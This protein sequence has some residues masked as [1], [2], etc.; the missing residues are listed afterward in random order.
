MKRIYSL[1]LALMAVQMMFAQTPEISLTLKNY[2][3]K[4]GGKG[5]GSSWA[6]AMSGESLFYVLSQKVTGATF[7]LAEGSYDWSSW[8]EKTTFPLYGSVTIIGGYDSVNYNYEPSKN[9]TKILNAPFNIYGENTDADFKGI[10]FD[11]SYIR[12]QAENVNLT[13]ENCYFTQAGQS[14]NFDRVVSNI[15]HASSVSTGDIKLVNDTF[16]VYHYSESYVYNY[17]IV[18]SRGDSLVIDNCCLRGNAR[19]VECSGKTNII[20]N[21]SLI[22][23]GDV[24]DCGAGELYLINN[25]ICYDG[26]EKRWY[27]AHG[28]SAG[29]T[30]QGLIAARVPST[31]IDVNKGCSKFVCGENEMS[32]GR[33]YSV[34]ID[35]DVPIYFYKN[36]FGITKDGNTRLDH[37]VGEAISLNSNASCVFPSDKDSSNYVNGSNHGLYLTDCS[38]LDIQSFIFNENVCAVEASGDLSSIQIHDNQFLANTTCIELST[39]ADGLTIKNNYF[40]GNIN[41]IVESSQRLGEKPVLIEKNIFNGVSNSAITLTKKDSALYKTPIISEVRLENKV[42]EIEGSIDTAIVADIELFYND[43]RDQSAIQSIGKYKTDKKGHFLITCPMSDIDGRSRYCFTATAI[44]KMGTSELSEKSCICGNDTTIDFVSIQPN[45]EFLGKV[46]TE[47]GKYDSVPLLLKNSI[48]CDS[49]VYYTVLVNAPFNASYYVKP[50][51]TGTGDGSSWKDAMSAE[52]FAK[53]LP[54]SVHNNTFYVAEGTYKPIYDENLKKPSDPRNLCYLI[55]GDVEII[56]GYPIDAKMS[57]KNNPD[58]YKT[59]FDGE[60]E[61]LIM[62]KLYGSLSLS[63]IKLKG[64]GYNNFGAI[65]TYGDNLGLTIENSEFYENNCVVKANKTSNVTIDGCSFDR[66]ICS[67]FG[68]VVCYGS[69]TVTNSIFS[70]NVTLN[71]GSAITFKGSKL[72]IEK[73]T[74]SENNITSEGYGG[75]VLVDGGVADI[76][77][78]TFFNNSVD[79]KSALH[80][81]SAISIIGGSECSL[82]NNTVI[83]NLSNTIPSVFVSGSSK[84]DMIGNIVLNNN[85]NVNSGSTITSS[86]N[87]LRNA[88]SSSATDVIVTDYKINTFMETEL[89]DNTG[90]TP[91]VAL[92]SDTLPDGTSLRFP[93]KQGKVSEDQRDVRRMTDMCMGSFELYCPNDT[94]LKYDSIYVGES[95]N[96]VKYN[97]V[98]VYDG[99]YTP[100]RTETGCYAILNHILF[101][102]PD[103]TVKK[104]YVKME[105]KNKGDGSNWRNA[106]NGD[107]F[108]MYVSLVPDG[109]TFYVAEGTYRPYRGVSYLSNQYEINSNVTIIGG[110]PSGSQDDEISEPDKYITRFDGDFGKNDVAELIENEYGKKWDF[111]NSGDNAYNLFC[112]TINKKLNVN[113]EGITLSN[114]GYG[115]YANTSK[116]NCHFNKVKFERIFNYCIEHLS[117]EGDVVVDNSKFSN[118]NGNCIYVANNANITVSNTSFVNNYGGSYLIYSSYGTDLILLDKVSVSE[119]STGGV[120]SYGDLIIRNSSFDSNDFSNYSFIAQYSGPGYKLQISNSSFTNNKNSNSYFVYSYATDNTIIESCLFDH[121]E[122]SPYLCQSNSLI[123]KDSKVSNNITGNELFYVYNTINLVRDTISSNKSTCLLKNNAGIS[124]DSC[125][126]NDNESYL[127]Y[128]QSDDSYNIS[129]SV[130]ENN[131]GKNIY[132]NNAGLFDIKYA[133]KQAELIIRNN[134]FIGNEAVGYFLYG[135]LPYTIS[136]CLF[137]KNKSGSYLIGMPS[138]GPTTTTGIYNSTFN[139][140]VSAKLMIFHCCGGTFDFNNNTVVSNIVELKDGASGIFELYAP[141]S[142]YYNYKVNNNTI[143]GNTAKNIIYHTDEKSYFEGNIIFGNVCD[144]YNSGCSVDANYVKNN[145]MPLVTYRKNDTYYLSNVKSNIL[146][147]FN[148]DKLTSDPEYVS[149]V[150]DAENYLEEITSL[151]AGTYDKSTGLFTPVLADNGGVTP[152]VALKSDKLSDGTSIRFPRLYNVLTDQRGAYRQD[153]TCMGAYEFGCSKDTVNAADTVVVGTKYK[154]GKVYNVIGRHDSVFITY[155]TKF[156]CDSVVNYTLFVVPN[157]DIKEFYVKTQKA[158]KGDG[159]D[160]DNA[161]GPKD[162]AY[163]FENLQTDGVTF[164]VAAGTYRAV[165]DGWGKETNNKNAH[166][167][168]RHSANIYGGYDSLATGDASTTKPNFDLYKT[169]FTGDV[170]NDD[171][172]KM[173][174]G[175]EYTFENFSDNMNSSMISMDVYGDVHISGVELTGMTFSHGT[176]PALIRL[177]AKSGTEYSATIDHCKLSVADKGIE[178]NNISNLSVDQCEFDYISNPAVYSNGDCKVSNSTFAYTAGISYSGNNSGLLVENSTFVM[179]RSDI[180][181]YNYDGKLSVS[182]QIYNNTFISCKNGAYLSFYDN[183]SAS[184]SGNIFAGSSISIY[185]RDGVAKQQTFTNNLLACETFEIGESGIDKDNV[186]VTDITTLYKDIFEGS[187]SEADAIFT[188][189]LTYKGAF[190]R[191]VALQK[192][193]LEDGTSIR[194]PRLKNVL[195]D[196]RGT[197]RFEETCMGAYEIGCPEDTTFAVDTVPVGTKIYGQTF[198][199]VGVHDSIFENL[200]SKNGCDSIVMHKVVVRPTAL[201]YY[202]KTKRVNKGDGRDWD[203]AMSGEDFATYLP[204]APDGATFYVAAG[205]YKPIYDAN[206]IIPADTA[207]I[208]Y[209]I[210]SS[211]TIIGGYP[212]TITKVGT[213]S[214]PTVNKTIFSGDI[215]GDDEEKDIEETEECEHFSI[216]KG[217]DPKKLFSVNIDGNCDITFKNLMITDANDGINLNSKNETKKINLYLDSIR[218]VHMSNTAIYSSGK[219]LL[220]VKNTD[221][222][223]NNQCVIVPMNVD[224]KKVNFEENYGIL[225]YDEGGEYARFDSCFFKG[226]MGALNSQCPLTITNSEFTESCGNVI[227]LSKTKED[228]IIDNC[229]FYDNSSDNIIVTQQANLLIDKSRFEKNI[230]KSIGVVTNNLT[231]SNSVFAEN[232]QK[233]GASLIVLYGEANLSNDTFNSNVVGSVIIGLSLDNSLFRCIFSNNKVDYVL[234]YSSGITKGI[235]EECWFDGNE[236]K[237]LVLA[238]QNGKQIFSK[239]TFSNN[240]ATILLYVTNIYSNVNEDVFVLF[241]NNSIVNN[242]VSKTLINQTFS[243]VKYVNNTIVGNNIGSEFIDYVYGYTQDVSLPF[244]GNLIFGNRFKYFCQHAL[245]YVPKYNLMPSFSYYAENTTLVMPDE[246]NIL[247]EYSENIERYKDYIDYKY[248]GESYF[249]NVKDRSVEISSLFEGTYDATTGIFTPVLKNNGG[250]TPTVALK[251]DVLPDGTS[252]RFPRLENVLADQRGVERLD[253]TCMGAYEMKCTPIITELKDTVV[254]GDSYTFNEKNLDDVCQKVGSYYFSDTLTG[255][256]GCDSIVNLSLAVRPQKNENG[257]YVKED[258]TG[259]GSD[260][261]NAMSPKDFAEFLPL[262]YDGETFH[263]AAGTYKS[264]YVDPELGRMYNINSSVTLIGGYPDT[265]MS[266]ATPSMPDLFVTKLTADVKNN[267]LIYYYPNSL[268]INSYYKFDDNDSILIRLNGEKTLNLFGLTLSGVNSCD[269][270]VVDLSEGSS[271]VMDHCTVEDNLA[272]AVYGKGTDVQVANSVFT[273]NYSNNG[274]AFHLVDSKL[275]VLSS[276]FH[277]NMANAT[278][279]C[280]VEYS[281][282]GVASLINTEATFENSTLVNNSADNGAVFS[283]LSSKLDLTNNTISGNQ[284]IPESKYKGSVISSLDDKSSVSLFG[285]LVIGNQQDEFDGKFSVNSTDYNVYSFKTDMSYGEHDMIMNN[286]KEVQMLLD[287]EMVYGS[288]TIYI[289]KVQ[290]NGG[291][292]PT[293]AVVQSPFDGGKILNIPLDDRKVTYDQR[294]FVRKDSSCIGAFEFPTYTGYYVKKQAHGDGSGRDWENSMSDTTF[295]KYFSIVPANASFYIAE[296]VYTP[297][298]DSYGKLTDD[299][300][301]RYSTSRLLNI[302]GGYP[303]SAQTGCEADPTKYK[304]IFSVDYNGDD[305]YLESTDEYSYIDALNTLDNGY[306]IVDISSKVPGSAEIKGV[307][308]RGQRSVP[309]ASS[310][311]LQVSGRS[312][313]GVNYRIEQCSFRSCYAGI[314]SSCDTFIISECLFDSMS[315]WGVSHSSFSLSENTYLLVEKSTFANSLDFVHAYSFNGLMRVQNCTFANSLYGLTTPGGYKNTPE[316]TRVEIYNNSFFPGKKGIC[317]MSI[318]DYVPVELI[319]NIYASDKLM[320]IPDGNKK[321]PSIPVV[322][323]YNVYTAE[324]DALKFGEN[325][326][327]VEESSLEGVI[328]GA[329]NTAANHFVGRLS[330]NGGFADNVAVL[331]TLVD[332]DIDIRFPLVNTNVTED[333]NNVERMEFTC[334]G[335]YEVQCKNPFV[336]EGQVM[337]E[338]SCPGSDGG[339]RAIVKI[340]DQDG[341]PMEGKFSFVNKAFNK[342]IDKDN[343]ELYEKGVYVLHNAGKP[344][345][346]IIVKSPD[347]VVVVPLS[348]YEP[349]DDEKSANIKDAIANNQTCYGINNGSI[350]IEYSDFHSYYD[351]SFAVLSLADNSILNKDV[352]DSKG[353]VKFDSVPAGTYK[354]YS[355]LSVEGCIIEGVDTLYIDT[356]E[357]TAPDKAMEILSISPAENHCAVEYDGSAEV[358]VAGWIPETGQSWKYFIADGDTISGTE[359]E[360]IS[361]DTFKIV[362]PNLKG[363]DYNFILSDAC[364]QTL[365]KPFEIVDNIAK[366]VTFDKTIVGYTCPSVSNGKITYNV[367]NWNDAYVAVFNGDTILP[368]TSKNGVATFVADNLSDSLC[369]LNVVNMCNEEISDSTDLYTYSLE[370]EGFTI[371]NVI[372]DA[373]KAKCDINARILDVTV[374]GGHKNEY[375]FCVTTLEG[376]TVEYVTLDSAHFLSKT[377]PDG[378]FK[379]I[380]SIPE[381]CTFEYDKDLTVAPTVKL[382]AR[383][384]EVM[385]GDKKS[386]LILTNADSESYTSDLYLMN[387]KGQWVLTDPISNGV[388]KKTITGNVTSNYTAVK[389]IA[390]G[391]EIFAPIEEYTESEDMLSEDNLT[392]KVLTVNQRCFN[393]KNGEFNL[394][395]SNFNSEYDLELVA[396][397]VYTNTDYISKEMNPDTIHLTD[398]D[399]GLYDVSIRLAIGGCA[400]DGAERSLGQY[401]IEGVESMLKIVKDTVSQS[402]CYSNFVASATIFFKDW[403]KDIYSWNYYLDDEFKFNGKPENIGIDTSIT[404]FADRGGLAK[405]AIFDVCKDTLKR[406]FVIDSLEKP[407]VEFL[408]DSSY[409]D[410]RCAYDSG[411]VVVK[412]KGGNRSASRFF[413]EYQTPSKVNFFDS[414]PSDSIFKIYDFIEGKP[415]TTSPYTSDLKEKVV[416]RLDSGTY[417][418]VYQNLDFENCKGDYDLDRI[419]VKRPAAV[420]LQLAKNDVR[421]YDK[422]EGIVNFVPIRAGRAWTKYTLA[423]DSDKTTGS[424]WAKWL[425]L[426]DKAQYEKY[427][428]GRSLKDEAHYYSGHVSESLPYRSNV[429]FEIAKIAITAK[430]QDSTALME[431]LKADNVKTPLAAMRYKG[432]YESVPT[433]WIGFNTLVADTYYVAVTDTF[434]CIY[435][436]SFS[437]KGPEDK[438]LEIIDVV[439]PAKDAY[440]VAD[441][442]RIKFSATGGWGEYIFSVRNLDDPN[443]PNSGKNIEELSE[444]EFYGGVLD[445]DYVQDVKYDTSYISVPEKDKWQKVVTYRSPIL[446]PGRHVI[447]V[448]DKEFCFATADTIL[449]DAKYTLDGK[450]FVDWCGDPDN[451]RLVPIVRGNAKVDSFSVR[452]GH[453]TIKKDSVEMRHRQLLQDIVDDNNNIVKGLGNLPMGKIGVIAYMEDGCSAFNEFTYERREGFVPL[454]IV[455]KEFK[456]NNC[457]DDNTGEVFIDLGGGNDMYTKFELDGVDVDSKYFNALY[458][459]RRFVFEDLDNDGVTDTSYT[460]SSEPIGF[461]ELVNNKDLFKKLNSKY[462]PRSVIEKWA[463]S[464]LGENP[465]YTDSLNA[466]NKLWNSVKNDSNYVI[467]FQ[468]LPW[469]NFL[470]EDSL[471]YMVVEDVKGCVD[472]LKFAIPHPDKLEIEVASSPVCPD[473]AGRLFAKT[474]KGG[475]PPYSWAIDNFSESEYDRLFP[476]DNPNK[477]VPKKPTVDGFVDFEGYSDFKDY[478]TGYQPSDH[479]PAMEGETHYMYIK[480]SHDCVVKSG[481]AKVDKKLTWDEISQ[482]FIVSTWHSYGDVLVIIDKTDYEGLKFAEDQSKYPYTYD[483]MHVEVVLKSPEDEYMIATPQ[484]KELYTYGIPEINNVNSDENQEELTVEW[485]GTKYVGPIWG[486]PAEVA[487]TVRTDEEYKQVS[488]QYN[489]ERGSLVGQIEGLKYQ[490]L[491]NDSIYNHRGRYVNVSTAKANEALARMIECEKE[492]KVLSDSLDRKY[493]DGSDYTNTICNISQIK[494]AFKPLVDEKEA[495]RMSFI[496]LEPTS[497]AGNNHVKEMLKNGDELPFLL[498]TTAYVDGC[499]ITTEHNL[500]LTFQD[501]IPYP[502]PN[503]KETLTLLPTPNPATNGKCIVKATLNKRLD[504]NNELYYYLV[505]ADGKLVLDNTKLEGVTPV[506]IKIESEGSNGE[507]EYEYNIPVEGLEPGKEYIFVA[508]TKNRIESAKILTK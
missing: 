163:I 25:K 230:I 52:T 97:K 426:D 54:L 164:Y 418:V 440:C 189:N 47:V 445:V 465:T 81:G 462:T 413:M 145:I 117:E 467:R 288:E 482:D 4:E 156:D 50:E 147:E 232:K 39:P 508:T 361:D 424:N 327:L 474:S 126:V 306:Y 302:Y 11:E 91:T 65:T 362:I 119:C 41:G 257:Y 432:D 460:E 379:V 260:W 31:I 368:E 14:L 405:F 383:K 335:A 489:T 415:D 95:F 429:F 181:T 205:T 336:A 292:T 442:R 188:P 151:F 26:I 352:R 391:C 476:K 385:C 458:F 144:V 240:N 45:D 6:K 452:I 359:A 374:K 148:Y 40:E 439:P 270:G 7:H 386:T 350:E 341:N 42:F 398:L 444:N 290:N 387:E 202:V 19:C 143:I 490:W 468:D 313:S 309:R 303:D 485:K 22:S 73:C 324:I 414:V 478:Y 356:L 317:G 141:G 102:K 430:N 448:F 466:Y 357:I 269:R 403:Q 401:H 274:A 67:Q 346:T 150:T 139:G 282:G 423:N 153:K 88:V 347:C 392:A 236:A 76:E 46:Y 165:Y 331:S 191:T 59:I 48:G 506:E 272:S 55:N 56:G 90:E 169:I 68:P 79:Y 278:E 354:V 160:W 493:G 198:T 15:S 328:D 101:V 58:V 365:E 226:N 449:I 330:N 402:K 314:Y 291:Y 170:K 138:G 421:C 128:S 451:N 214:N 225:Y 296:G 51:A 2:Y 268:D 10:H 431:H 98:G 262:V 345:D 404:I 135:T 8:N 371:T 388:Y 239:S 16:D 154:D 161:M 36:Y 152:T 222:Y 427:R 434:G 252:I 295:A 60:L 289:P 484:M 305:K 499:D 61:A 310:A 77:N 108:L 497:K 366:P 201:N 87:L 234:N 377:L 273:H 483:S 250:F 284:I 208:T 107:D 215:L 384:T 74:F 353:V 66:N 407:S 182:A 247:S 238:A 470:A 93:K 492:V 30:G 162:F 261:I 326:K 219:G 360:Q 494:S 456:A 332:D 372:F 389:S 137:E 217:T 446:N 323:D 349:T 84:V 75:A 438:K 419:T 63:G 38:N 120:Q 35:G 110:F 241:E 159:S 80:S 283:I 256:G 129:N 339:L 249:E 193:T 376:D 380:A 218:F 103:S 125:L 422:A 207:T 131:V 62:F 381:G 425:F 277:E 455:A 18:Y 259:D 475:V 297:M 348:V 417:T 130:F 504:S 115:Y 82:Y 204:L 271:L 287:G 113:F 454:E 180:Q 441:N 477:I 17:L 393:V 213:P 171:N 223:R 286:P 480:D 488:E 140:N 44:Y 501:S 433:D 184:V 301:R 409:V 505:E 34:K 400:L 133:N 1:I 370:N 338:S 27:A 157:P 195:K 293:V 459:K 399:S 495:L 496:K 242:E 396:H 281:K 486:I 173:T 285:N 178:A 266:I 3:V 168:S 86:Y 294:G 394:V 318:Y 69:L 254:V 355:Y 20:K 200:V 209:R 12:V 176:S 251:K 142:D 267:D 491:V 316:N 100:G 248:Y 186:K 206:G 363:G 369:I 410:L 473:G 255:S 463:Y 279:Y 298:V 127:A 57:T 136:E 187:Y 121:N 158:G 472:T 457:F 265:V 132:Q 211:V 72:K 220:K 343:V 85:I 29:R 406:E 358:T 83:S 481:V 503:Y 320:L 329:Y 464:N 183:V 21:S 375:N 53:Y 408:V 118:S 104:Y 312:I 96:G 149:K 500:M 71:D 109:T 258:G 9:I 412:L 264:T 315:A 308:F 299:K 33:M 304:T 123:M 172:V 43:G 37:R 280:D 461:P 471:H 5:D 321:W 416:C 92:I 428:L 167:V 436:D 342:T 322:S 337:N 49:L 334:A 122:I 94:V 146:S 498:R 32:I 106:M 233:E 197:S 246:T 333:Q 112:S 450:Q 228:V 177:N 175:C 70:K 24:V 364:D 199:K 179:N 13:V 502:V 373:D 479:I 227:V 378:Q 469:G 319:G 134:K 243:Y 244:V 99:I 210:N 23:V 64:S 307:E 507:S 174:S 390:D 276:A 367:S 124:I 224:F 443:D 325:D 340:F 245:N 216:T 487:V 420:K 263:I 194:F 437:V 311:A 351:L 203:N 300:S 212:D 395:Y 435:V 111:S 105:R 231:S 192:D 397:N 221:F 453:A 235:V 411:Y 237:Y 190:T 114:A 344:C 116:L 89:R 447:S 229:K 196:Q 28:Y 78:S 275:N 166:W 155:K 185:K 382:T 253:L